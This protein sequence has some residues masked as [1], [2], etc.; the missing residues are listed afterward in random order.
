MASGMNGRDGTLG[1]SLLRADTS[2]ATNLGIGARIGVEGA[3]LRSPRQLAG[4]GGPDK[5][6]TLATE[7]GT[8]ATALSGPSVYHSGK[9][10]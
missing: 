5:R 2:R 9:W 1:E 7:C 8:L 6:Q 10:W 4:L 3:M